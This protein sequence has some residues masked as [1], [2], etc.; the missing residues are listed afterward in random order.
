MR[1]CVCVCETPYGEASVQPVG[2][3]VLV[4]R[5]VAE[6]RRWGADV[7]VGPLPSEDP[8]V[9]AAGG[10]HMLLIHP[11]QRRT[12]EHRSSSSTLAS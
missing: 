4:L 11:A 6:A 9:Q 3:T 10:Q 2:G 12:G 1:V 5:S 7:L 8:L